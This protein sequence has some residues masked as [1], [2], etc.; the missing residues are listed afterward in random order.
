MKLRL[1]WLVVLAICVM[2][3]R[4]WN[5][6]FAE[7]LGCENPHKHPGTITDPTEC[8]ICGHSK[9]TKGGEIEDCEPCRGNSSQPSSA[10]D[11]GNLLSNGG[12]GCTG[13]GGGSAGAFGVTGADAREAINALG[14]NEAAQ[15]IAIASHGL[16]PNQTIKSL[17]L[18]RIFSSR[19]KASD[20]PWGCLWGTNYDSYLLVNRAYYEQ[21]NGTVPWDWTVELIFHA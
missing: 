17:E 19:S 2:A 13:C 14:G 10:E 7:T 15:A 11:T 1:N 5:N 4:T 6:V 8:K 9:P 16:N 3:T 18:T 21:P 12:F 20:S